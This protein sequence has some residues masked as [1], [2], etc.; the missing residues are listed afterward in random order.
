MD[1]RKSGMYLFVVMLCFNA[2]S[3][4]L[5]SVGI[6]GP[7]P[8]PGFPSGFTGSVDPQENLE[9]YDWAVAYSDF[10]K[11]VLTIIDTMGGLILYGFPRLLLNSGVPSFI[12]TPLAAIWSLMWF[13]V[14]LLNYVGGR[15]T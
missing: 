4:M 6:V 8:K 12:V 14:F 13:L 3:Q 2:V 10:V 5:Y 11:G 7:Q 1:M 9:N 15:D